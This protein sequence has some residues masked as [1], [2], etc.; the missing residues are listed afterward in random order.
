M[1]NGYKGMM[2]K[3]K[4][5][6]V[7]KETVLEILE[8]W[9]D[10]MGRKIKLEK[11]VGKHTLDAVD[12]G[13]GKIKDS[14]GAEYE[15]AQTISFRLDGKVYIAIEDPI[16][17]Y[18]SCMKGLKVSYRKLMKNTFFPIEVVGVYRE[19]SR[20][21][22]DS[23]K[24][25][26]LIATING[27]LILEVGTEHSDDYYPCFVA[28]FS[29]ENIRNDKTKKKEQYERQKSKDIIMIMNDLITVNKEDEIDIKTIWKKEFKRTLK[30][31]WSSMF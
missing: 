7:I 14:Y 28:H 26:E 29:P 15:D 18:R 23:A 21:G 5:N 11:L 19:R 20:N 3:G 30:G 24:V 13:I 31:Q 8:D 17:G 6:G 1:N 27:K 12:F 22:Y 25:L 9:D 2:C 16:D 10:M 4:S